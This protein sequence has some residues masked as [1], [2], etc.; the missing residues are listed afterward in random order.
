MEKTSMMSFR[1]F[2][3][4]YCDLPTMLEN[5][6]IV[7][8]VFNV[9]IHE[10]NDGPINIFLYILWIISNICYYYVYVFS[11]SWFVIVRCPQTGNLIAVSVVISLA[12]C[13]QPSFIKMFYMII[14]KKKVQ[15]LIQNYLLLNLLVKPESS[16][17][18]NLHIQLRFIKKRATT[19]WAT[20]AM[21]GILYIAVPIFM[22]GR[23]LAEDFLV[24]YGLEPMLESPNFE[25]ASAMIGISVYLCVCSLGSITA[26]NLIII[27]YSESQM[28]SLSKEL[29]YLWQDAKDFTTSLQKSIV[30]KYAKKTSIINTYITERL[31]EI[32]F[33]HIRN[34]QVIEEFE[35]V[36]SITKAIEFIFIILAIISELLGG[37]E[38]TYL[39]IPFSFVLI[40]MECFAGQ[41]LMDA[42]EMFE[43]AIYNCNWEKFN[44]TNRRT[45]LMMLVSAQ[46]TLSI[47]AGGMAALNFACLL[48]VMKFSYST[49]NTLRL[50]VN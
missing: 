17:S 48:S 34:I 6:D 14:Y 43:R 35:S 3:L 31:K 11:V 49:Y 12:M 9:K 13:S 38:N 5:L 41:K 7:L 45:I 29:N 23:H 36:F 18:K 19:V 33:L 27:G 8:R 1:K 2:G 15:S 20:M 24:I 46:K 25:I 42:C 28:I 47:S 21:N 32:I 30:Y 26:M 10:N 40:L 4:D 44:V 16:F 39:Q 37:I 22:P 50:M